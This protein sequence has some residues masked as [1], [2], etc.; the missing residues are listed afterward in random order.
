MSDDP[1]IPQRVHGIGQN[2]TADSLD[3][4][5]G[6]LGTVTL[7]PAPFL[8]GVGAHVSDGLAAELV[9]ANPGFEVS[10]PPSGRKLDE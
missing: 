10:K 5:L 3:D 2:I 4:V 1:I 7:D 9:L 8:L 6:E